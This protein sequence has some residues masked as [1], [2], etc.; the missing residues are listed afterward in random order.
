MQKFIKNTLATTG[1]TL[2]VLAIIAT[3]FKAEWLLI[4]SIYQSFLA[5]IIIQVG[6]IF[7][8]KF[9]SKYF[10]IEIFLEIGYVLSVL[11]L[12]GFLFD[13]YGSTPVWIV[14]LMGVGIYFIGYFI[15]VLKINDDI[16]FIN[17]QLKTE[18]SK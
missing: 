13:W 14:I 8:H 9:E 4:D 5:N 3:I 6:L 17:K 15:N 10:I 2:I 11:I 16:A 1:L 18:Q 12:A 7:V